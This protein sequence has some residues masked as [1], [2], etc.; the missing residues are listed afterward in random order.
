LQV[1]GADGRA[2]MA[3]LTLDEGV[4]ELDLDGFSEY[5]NRQ[6]PSYARP[7]FLRI[8]PEIDVTGTFKMVKGKLREEGYDP[9]KVTDPLYRDEA[10][11]RSL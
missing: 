6:L 5:V 2:G 8:E 3:A 4:G 10:G 1:P 7:L 11:Q 9:Q